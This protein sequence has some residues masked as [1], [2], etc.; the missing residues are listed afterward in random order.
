MNLDVKMD[1]KLEIYSQKLYRN[2]LDCISRPGQI[3][4]IKKMPQESK[5]DYNN[6]YILGIAYT[7]LDTETGFCIVEEN[8]VEKKE[9]YITLLTN[10][11]SVSLENAD[12]IFMDIKEDLNILQ[13]AKNGTLNYPDEGATVILS[14]LK[15]CES[16]N[17][18]E[19]TMNGPG[20]E[21][22]K[23]VNVEGIDGFF[24]DIFNKINDEFPLGVD[25]LLLSEDE[26]K[27]MFLPRSIKIGGEF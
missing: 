6:P 12:F 20:I 2:M 27:F 4:E 3:G 8:D 19:I 21:E 26:G 5:V 11:R 7:L 23:K 16:N 24:V 15:F 17:S 10:A 18:I 13:R 9:Q 22:Q 25:I 14:G 1:N